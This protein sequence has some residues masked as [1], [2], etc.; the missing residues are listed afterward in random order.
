VGYAFSP[1]YLL[2]TPLPV[3]QKHIAKHTALPQKPTQLLGHAQTKG[4]TRPRQLQD[5]LILSYASSRLL[6]VSDELSSRYWC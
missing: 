5:S 3:T 4:V 1:S 2:S 6:A